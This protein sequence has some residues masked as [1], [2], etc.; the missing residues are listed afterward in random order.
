[1]HIPYRTVQVSPLTIT[2]EAGKVEL[3]IENAEQVL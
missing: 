3:T 1:M 2:T